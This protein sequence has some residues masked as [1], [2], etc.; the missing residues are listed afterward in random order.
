M[1]GQQLKDPSKAVGGGLVVEDKAQELGSVSGRAGRG[2]FQRPGE[3][4]RGGRGPA[5]AQHR[6]GGKSKNVIRDGFVNVFRPAR[7]ITKLLERSLGGRGGSRQGL[8]CGGQLRKEVTGSAGKSLKTF[9]AGFCSGVEGAQ[10]VAP[11][12]LGAAPGAGGGA[13][14]ATATTAS[15]HGGKKLASSMA[16]NAM[17]SA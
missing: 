1:Y 16:S 13:C 14:E 3:G 9:R 10:S 15:R 17:E 4:W 8:A 11:F 5:R 2:T 7:R 12:G 6:A